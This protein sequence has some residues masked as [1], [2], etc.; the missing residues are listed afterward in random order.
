MITISHFGNAQHLKG[1]SHVKAQQI[2][3]AVLAQENL[4]ENATK[5]AIEQAAFLGWLPMIEDVRLCATI[6]QGWLFVEFREPMH[7]RTIEIRN[8]EIN[9]AIQDLHAK[10]LEQRKLQ[11]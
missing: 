7:R 10:M 1:T 9:A 5:S 2:Y 8:P 4:S 11:K 6:D 3:D